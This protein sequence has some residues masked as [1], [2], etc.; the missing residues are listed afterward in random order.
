MMKIESV[1]YN[2]EAATGI[3]FCTNTPSLLYATH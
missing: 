3:I 1:S 2:K